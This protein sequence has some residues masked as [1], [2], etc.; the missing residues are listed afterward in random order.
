LR[1]SREFPFHEPDDGGGGREHLKTGAGT[2]HVVGQR[3]DDPPSIA[4]VGHFVAGAVP[5]RTS[6]VR[7]VSRVGAEPIRVGPMAAIFVGRDRRVVAGAER[8]VGP[9]VLAVG[10]HGPAEQPQKPIQHVNSSRKEPAC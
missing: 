5:Q 7:A 8:A 3:E 4:V 9:R 6:D 1:P 2:D 10:T